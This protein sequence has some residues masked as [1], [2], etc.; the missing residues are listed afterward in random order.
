[1]EHISEFHISMR[2]AVFLVLQE[3]PNTIYAQI[4]H[5]ETAGVPAKVYPPPRVYSGGS[6]N[7]P[8]GCK[9]QSQKLLQYQN[10]NSF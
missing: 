2:E 4:R 9:W 8:N 6:Y 7:M 1:M 3:T 10:I 5:H